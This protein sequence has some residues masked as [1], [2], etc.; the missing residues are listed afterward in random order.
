MDMDPREQSVEEWA[1]QLSDAEPARRLEAAAALGRL[2]RRARS[3]V[4]QLAAALKD[5]NVLVRKMAALA[6]GDIGAAAG[7]AALTEALNDGE[8]SVRRRA[9]VAL[10][11]IAA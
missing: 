8:E 1:V 6:L 10:R 2:R 5:A 9:A 11:E 7:V 3:A 4:P